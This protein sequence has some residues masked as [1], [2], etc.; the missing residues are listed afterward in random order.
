HRHHGGWTLIVR[1]RVQIH[2]HDEEEDDQD[3]GLVSLSH[4][5]G[6]RIELDAR[7]ELTPGEADY[8]EERVAAARAWLVEEIAGDEARVARAAE[9]LRETRE[10]V[11]EVGCA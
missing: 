4:V 1:A 3:V 5:D 9:V 10:R 6:R 7:A 2:A 11:G 8:L